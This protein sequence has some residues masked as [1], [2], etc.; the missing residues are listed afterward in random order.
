MRF[1]LQSV[2]LWCDYLNFVQEHD[3][4]VSECSA[5]GIAKARNL[6]ECAL[7]AAGLHFVEGSKIWE[8]YR[9][10]E[11]AVCLTIDE[12]DVEIYYYSLGFS[13]FEASVAGAGLSPSPSP[14]VRFQPAILSPTTFRGAAGWLFPRFARPLLVSTLLKPPLKWMALSVAA[15]G[16]LAGVTV[17]GDFSGHQKVVGVP[18]SA[19]WNEKSWAKTFDALTEIINLAFLG[20]S[21]ALRRPLHQATPAHRV[22]PPPLPPPPPPPGC[23]PKC[24][25]IGEPECCLR[26]IPHIV[27]T[28][29]SRKVNEAV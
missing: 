10:F 22:V 19:G 13:L 21:G 7:T 16:V 24:G 18:V 20:T 29:S 14:P 3:P 23:C 28:K 2:P 27:A 15:G 8:A 6:F 17:A 12:S 9:E 5:A 26:S 11:Q 4:S 1:L 25:F